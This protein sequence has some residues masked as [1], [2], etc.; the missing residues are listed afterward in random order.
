MGGQD[1]S[2]ERQSLSE[3][4]SGT[5][6]NKN[7]YKSWTK[8]KKQKTSYIYCVLI[9]QE[10]LKTCP[11]W[12]VLI[13]LFIKCIFNYYYYYFNTFRHTHKKRASCHWLSDKTFLALYIQTFK[14]S[15]Y[16]S[17]SCSRPSKSSQACLTAR[18]LWSLT[19]KH[20]ARRTLPRALLPLI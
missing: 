10:N 8:K 7:F 20:T 14:S 6:E 19:N 1:L 3:R 12:D 17:N 11:L 5:W 13:S 4:G 2:K 9:S 16:C 15:I 18:H